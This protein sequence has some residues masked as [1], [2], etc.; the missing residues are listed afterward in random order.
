MH[1]QFLAAITMAAAVVVLASASHAGELTLFDGKAAPTVVYDD[2]KSAAAGQG[3]AAAGARSYRPDWQ[4]ADRDAQGRARAGPVVIFGLAKSPTIAALLKANHIDA[5]RLAGQWEDLRSRPDHPGRRSS[6]TADLRLRHARDDLG[7]DGPVARD[8]RLALGSGGP[9]SRSVRWTTSRSAATCTTPRAR[10]SSI[11]GIFLN[12]EEFGLYPWASKTNDPQLHDVGPRTYERV[13]ELMWRLKANTFWPAMRGIEKSFN[14][15]PAAPRW[16]RLWPGAGQLARRD[17]LA[18]QY[19][20]VGR[21][22][23]GPYNIF[24]NRK[25]VM[26][27]WREAVRRWGKNDNMYTVGMRGIEDRPAAG[28]QHPQ[29]Q[30]RALEQ[31]FAEQRKMLGEEL[32]TP[33]DQVPQVFTP[34]KEV[35]PAYDSGPEGAG[36]RDAELAGRQLRLHP[37]AQ[38]RQGA[39]ALGRLG[40]L[41]PHFVLGLSHVVPAAGQQP[42]RLDVGGDEQGLPV[43]RA[44]AVDRQCRRHQ[45]GRVPGPAV[46]R[47][48]VRQRRLSGCRQR[49]EA[50]G[51]AGPPRTSAR[52]TATGSPTSCGGSTTWPSPAIP[53]SWAGPPPSR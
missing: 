43:R 48:G 7:R 41:L 8:G 24:E 49:Q 12:D 25:R 5:A 51:R 10:R 40:R 32:K 1:R 20:R 22:D 36:R 6:G 29:D 23:D 44:A 35:L 42:S 16:L 47:H 39:R 14:Q 38:Q 26:D 21:R 11:S 53:N 52:P 3:R 50:P 17:D 15:I 31:V 34:Y 30:A 2:A 45:A 46:P 27:Y 33:L 13:Y 4:G 19:P 9:T 37:P 18:D 28:R